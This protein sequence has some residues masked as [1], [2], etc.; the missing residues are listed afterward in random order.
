M[1]T[2]SNPEKLEA[3]I[4]GEWNFEKYMESK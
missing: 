3:W 2:I 4:R 1:E